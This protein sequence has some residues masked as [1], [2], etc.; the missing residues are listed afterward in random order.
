M[1]TTGAQGATP[2]N[3]E[4]GVG[5][6]LFIDVGV[7]SLLLG[8]ARKRRLTRAFGTPRDEQSRLGDDEGE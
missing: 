6:M 7:R 8:E 5:T 2:H 1:S 3:R 4:P